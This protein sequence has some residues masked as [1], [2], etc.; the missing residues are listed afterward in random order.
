MGMTQA[1]MANWLGY[2]QK[3]VYLWE[4]GEREPKY[5]V[6]HK[7]ADAANC[8]IDWLLGRTNIKDASVLKT[9]IIE[10]VTIADAAHTG[11]KETI[12]TMSKEDLD[13]YI[14]SRVDEAIKAR[15]KKIVFIPEDSD[16]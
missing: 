4:S 1:D 11:I 3:A 13:A 12:H 7:I 9:D 5:E 8:S 14:A 2:T 6:L 10:A 15:V 16:K